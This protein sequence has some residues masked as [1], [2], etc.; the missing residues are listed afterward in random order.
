MKRDVQL[1][2]DKY[3]TLAYTHLLDD[4]LIS[5][6]H[7]HICACTHLL[8]N[9]ILNFEALRGSPSRSFKPGVS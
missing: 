1:C 2:L 6:Q 4:D 8:N 7:A 5:A 9:D 3:I